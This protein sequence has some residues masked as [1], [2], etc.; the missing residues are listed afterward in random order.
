MYV[1]NL[2]SPREK[3]Y[4]KICSFMALYPD[5]SIS[6]VNLKLSTTKI[7]ANRQRLSATA[8][9]FPNLQG[10]RQ[11]QET[12]K[13][14]AYSP[15][16]GSFMIYP[17]ERERAYCL[18]TVIDMIHLAYKENHSINRALKEY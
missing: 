4:N 7:Y 13:A 9:F 2:H 3:V 18:N 11:P 17:R 15:L 5:F 8:I 10:D 12:N 16:K 14:R 6:A 1:R